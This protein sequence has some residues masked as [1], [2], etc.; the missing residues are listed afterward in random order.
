MLA[1]E[2][3]VTPG[4]LNPADYLTA[5]SDWFKRPASMI[6]PTATLDF[7]KANRLDKLT[8]RYLNGGASFTHTLAP[9]VLSAGLGENIP[10]QLTSAITLH[11]DLARGRMSKGRIFPPS[12]FNTGGGST[13]GTNGIMTSAAAQ[14]MA[15][16]AQELLAEINS[17]SQ[18]W[19]VVVWSQAAQ[20]AHGVDRV[21]CGRVVDTQRRRRN[22]LDESRVFAASNV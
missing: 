4:D 12:T 17:V 21:S 10:S 7:I 13:I 16:S 18:T 11:T 5:L 1:E 3:I 22:Q 19:T 14:G 8:Q 2:A 9:A 6:Q 15:D 20:G